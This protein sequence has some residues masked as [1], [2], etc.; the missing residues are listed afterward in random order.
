MQMYTK[1]HFSQQ[2]YGEE[3]G[4][5]FDAEHPTVEPHTSTSAKTHASRPRSARKVSEQ[6]STQTSPSKR[7]DSLSRKDR[8]KTCSKTKTMVIDI[9]E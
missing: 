1:F 8:Y 3:F 4:F 6:S 9:I 7:K 2:I 5:T